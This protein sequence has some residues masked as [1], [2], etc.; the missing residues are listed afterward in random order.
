MRVEIDG[1]PPHQG[2]KQWGETKE[3]RKEI[4]PKQQITGVCIRQNSVGFRW[5][6]DKV[7]NVKFCIKTVI[8]PSHILQTFQGRRV[9]GREHGSQADVES[10]WRSGRR[11]GGRGFGGSQIADTFGDRRRRHRRRW[12][13]SW[14][15]NDKF[16]K[17]P[18]IR[19]IMSHDVD[20]PNCDYYAHDFHV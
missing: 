13:W 10:G 1:F 15:R 6:Y 4:K 18:M 17:F 9:E 5:F 19:V 11:G 16:D 14:G 3:G 7:T 20:E 12:W 8:L 2:R